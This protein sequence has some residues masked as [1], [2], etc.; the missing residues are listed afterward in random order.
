[1]QT[2]HSKP[3]DSLNAK[4]SID[5]NFELDASLIHKKQGQSTKHPLPRVSREEGMQIDEIDE[6]LENPKLPRHEI[7]SQTLKQPRQRDETEKGRNV[8]SHQ[9]FT[10]NV[11]TGFEG[12]CGQRPTFR[13]TT[14]GKLCHR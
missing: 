5:E 12:D 9:R 7:N 4:S 10:Q 13:K 1:M 11:R 14:V 8:N 3:P 2:T 6:Q